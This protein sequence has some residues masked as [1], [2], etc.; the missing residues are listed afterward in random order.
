MEA[1]LS[2]GS[3]GRVPI[4][5]ELEAF[6]LGPSEIRHR[7][8]DTLASRCAGSAGSPDPDDLRDAL[9]RELDLWASPVLGETDTGGLPPRLV[10]RAAYRRLRGAERWPEALGRPDPDPELVTALRAALPSPLP[11]EQTATMVVEPLQGWSVLTLLRPFKLAL[12]GAAAAF[13]RSGAS[14]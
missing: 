1:H 6:G 13:A 11:P 8:V 2:A 14:S 12:R 7:L 5:A 3:A 9:N 10:V 4:E